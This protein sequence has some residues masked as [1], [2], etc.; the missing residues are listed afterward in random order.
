MGSFSF[1]NQINFEASS[2]ASLSEQ[3][4]V[5]GDYVNLMWNTEFQ[6]KDLSSARGNF[7]D[8]RMPGFSDESRFQ[9]DV[10]I[11]FDENYVNYWLF[12]LLYQEKNFSLVET[13]EKIAKGNQLANMALRI[14][15]NTNV[16]GVFM[17][18]IKSEHG[19]GRPVDFQCGM[20]KKFL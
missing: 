15:M 6:G 7:R 3:M 14:L 18:E 10:Q 11:V 16:I 12:S 8:V 9:K 19:S 5:Q 1:K 2:Q 17:P 4:S 13:V 20:N